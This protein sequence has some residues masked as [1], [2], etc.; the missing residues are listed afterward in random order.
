[1]S[2][3]TEN[4]TENMHICDDC[5]KSFHTKQGFSQY[6]RACQTRNNSRTN[7][8]DAQEVFNVKASSQNSV[9]IEVNFTIPCTK[10][11][12]R[13]YKYYNFEKYL[14][15]VY[16][17][18]VFW[19]EDIFLLLSGKAGRKF[20]DEVS[21]LMNEWLKDSTLKDIV[22]KAIMVMLNLLLQKP[23]HKIKIKGS[24]RGFEKKDGHL[25]V[26]RTNGLK[27]KQL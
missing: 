20:I 8:K 16:E 14:S 9:T 22:F 17:K 6:Q 2:H 27:L 25:G 21:R 5:D 11:M 18:T 19:K 1:M 12:W 23:S 13:R 7:S 15:T 24:P 4:A 10:Y 3:A 26:R